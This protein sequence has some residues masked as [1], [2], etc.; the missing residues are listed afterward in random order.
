MSDNQKP[1]RDPGE[2]VCGHKNQM[3]AH[4]MPCPDCHPDLYKPAPKPEEVCERCG[5]LRSA[6]IHDADEIDSIRPGCHP[7]KPAPKQEEV[8]AHVE[9]DGKVCGETR[10]RHRKL[11]F[12]FS[13]MHSFEPAPKAPSGDS[14]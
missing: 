10:E 12:Q 2:E 3:T 5:H 7:Y 1:S 8:C 11:E 9:Y 14:R 6:V 4:G 13:N